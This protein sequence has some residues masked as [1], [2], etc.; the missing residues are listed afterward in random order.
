MDHGSG[1]GGKGVV[2]AEFDLGDGERVVLIDNWDDAH[3]KERVKRVDCIE[4]LRALQRALAIC[5]D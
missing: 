1:D 5:K 4:I 2:V 3:L